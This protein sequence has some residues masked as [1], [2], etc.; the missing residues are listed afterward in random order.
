[1]SSVVSRE[2]AVK[3]VGVSRSLALADRLEQG[4]LALVNF[5]SVLTDAQWQTRQPKDG[6]KVGVVV[7][8][9]ASVYPVEIE[10]AQTL[11]A[12]KPVVG[13]TMDDLHKMNAQHARDNG[14][15]TCDRRL[16]RPD[17]DH[18]DGVRGQVEGHVAH[19]RLHG[20]HAAE[21]VGLRE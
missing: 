21:L 20:F 6:R 2:L 10:L 12:G 1:M 17:L 8:H 5:A 13:D 9:V 7:H 3:P 14:A 16:V 4:A 11:A 19:V 15:A 18:G